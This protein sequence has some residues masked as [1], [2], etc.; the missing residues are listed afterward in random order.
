MIAS[1]AM[2]THDMFWMKITHTANML[3]TACMMFCHVM[4]PIWII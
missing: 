4:L 1:V 3:I 2:S